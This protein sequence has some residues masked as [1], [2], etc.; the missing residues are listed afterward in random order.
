MKEDELE[1]LRQQGAVFKSDCDGS[2]RCF[3]ETGKPLT[4]ALGRARLKA[5]SST[6]KLRRAIVSIFRL[7]LCMP[8][9]AVGFNFNSLRR[10]SL[11]N[12]ED[13]VQDQ[14]R[15]VPGTATKR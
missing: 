11:R 4:R 1:R 9:E 6:A 7:L 15:L 10:S 5:S 14:E 8:I 2:M 3:A 13:T 12:G